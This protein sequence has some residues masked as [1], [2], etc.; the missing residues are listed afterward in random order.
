VTIGPQDTFSNEVMSNIVFE[1]NYFRSNAM[2]RLPVFSLHISARDVTVRNNIFNASEAGRDYTSI[3][4]L[5]RQL[6]PAPDNVQ[7]YNNLTYRSDNVSNNGTPFSLV[8]IEPEAT[9][10]VVMNNIISAPNLPANFPQQVIIGAGTSINSNNLVSTNPLFV[11]SPPLFPSDFR[12]TTGSPL[13]DAGTVV[14]GVQDDFDGLH[15]PQGAEYDIGPY[16]FGNNVNN[17]P[18]VNAG[19]D[20]TVAAPVN[21]VTLAGNVSDDGLP[22]PPGQTT[23]LWSRVS[24]PG[25]VIFGNA[26]SLATTATFTQPG[27][28]VLRLTSSDSALSGSD[29]VQITV[30][31]EGVGNGNGSGNNQVV[32]ETKLVPCSSPKDSQ[33]RSRIPVCFNVKDAGNVS[34]TIYSRHGKKVRELLNGHRDAGENRVDWDLK[35]D[36]GGMVSSGP[37]TVLFEENGVKQKMKLIV[38]R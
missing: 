11:V 21:T 23:V 32:T 7:I 33:E 27:V 18:I 28:Y 36:S 29:D 14:A 9:R 3:N 34:I 17:R 35:D 24:G 37:F 31:E 13:I 12:V 25:N 26:S 20:Q 22:N 16:E 8:S 30:N 5:R 10:T 38:I 1:R 4:V 6:E 19:A 15:R 2:G